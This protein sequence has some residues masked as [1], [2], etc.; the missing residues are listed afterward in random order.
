MQELTE[1]LEARFEAA[2]DL[3]KEYHEKSEEYHDLRTDKQWERIT[4]RLAETEAAIT[5]METR[6][7][8]AID[9]LTNAVAADVEGRKALALSVAEIGDAV[10]AV[11]AFLTDNPAPSPDV[12]ANL[13]QQL[14]TAGYDINVAAATLHASSVQLGTL[15]GITPPP[16]SPAPPVVDPAP[17]VVVPVDP[18]PPVDPAPPVVDPAPPVAPPTD[19]PVPTAPAP[20]DPAPAS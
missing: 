19:P 18:T 20:T 7:M 9:D 10:T 3:L 11:S 2:H 5:Q 15:A 6:I 16:T 14:S 1:W 8:A 17:P 4:S 13:A 12:I